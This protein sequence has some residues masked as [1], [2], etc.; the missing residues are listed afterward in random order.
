MIITNRWRGAGV[1][2]ALCAVGA[3]GCGS[4]AIEGVGELGTGRMQ[5]INGAAMPIDVRVDGVVKVSGLSAASLSTAL[6]LPVGSH[7]V[8]LVAAG[9]TTGGASVTVVIAPD[10]RRVIAAT[11]AASG[12]GVMALADTGSLVGVGRSKLRVLNLA[13][14][15]PPLDIWRTQPDYQMPISIM[16][17][18][19]YRSGATVESTTGVWEV[20]VW[21]T[22]AGSWSSASSALTIAIGSAQLRT[23]VT[24]DAPGGG[25]KLQ[26]LDP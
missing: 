10:V 4:D 12:V 13:A 26:L 1:A 7:A 24:L 17:P 8:Q 11:Q 14:N 5:V 18:Y 3:V 23:V 6:T 9:S 19:A 2:L 21:P 22:G 20:R 25:V 15:A 16:F